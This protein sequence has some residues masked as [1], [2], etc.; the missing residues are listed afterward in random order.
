[1]EKQ[2][3][4]QKFCSKKEFKELLVISSRLASADETL[5]PSAIADDWPEDKTMKIIRAALRFKADMQLA[6]QR[7]WKK[8]MKKYSLPI[9]VYINPDTREFYC[10]KPD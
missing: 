5:H 9:R 3:Y 7:W 4:L 8:I 10:F 6:E 1:M 2:E